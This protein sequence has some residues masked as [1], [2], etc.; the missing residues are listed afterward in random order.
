MSEKWLQGTIVVGV[1]ASDGGDEDGFLWVGNHPATDLCNTMPVIGGVV[2]DL[3][4]D[5][6]ELLRW[7]RAIGLP[8]TA[9]SGS[10]RNQ[11]RTN[12]F[13]HELRAALHDAL[14]HGF[15]GSGAPATIN[16]ILAEEPGSL[17]VRSFGDDT[18]ENVSFTST[19]GP[20]RFRL[21]L[22]ATIIDIFNYSPTR[23]R[24]CARPECVLMFLD[25]SKSGRR[26]WCDMTT[27]GNRAKAA[28]HYARS[29]GR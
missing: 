2:V 24:T 18:T 15:S 4:P 11:Q 13:V 23:I 14:L 21:S 10:A 7:A 17:H 22:A 28:A 3:L 1:A 29:K 12:R 26:R 5:H 8:T 6:D 25:T 27:C 9:V 20:G 16:A 19:T